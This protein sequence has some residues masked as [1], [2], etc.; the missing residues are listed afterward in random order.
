MYIKSKEKREWNNKTARPTDR[1][2]INIHPSSQ[3]TA[4]IIVY[5]INT[6]ACN[7]HKSKTACTRHS[8][9]NQVIF[10]TVG[11]CFSLIY[12]FV[13]ETLLILL[14][15]ANIFKVID[16]DYN[17]LVNISDFFFFFFFF[18]CLFLCF[19]Y[20]TPTTKSCS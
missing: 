20:K 7:S 4:A 15:L 17:F 18:F 9:L 12:I 1:P 6:L 10:L 16:D 11:V 13:L 3:P 19:G 14:L 2:I 5:K 8:I